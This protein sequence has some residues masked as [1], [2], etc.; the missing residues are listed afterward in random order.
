MKR[1]LLLVFAAITLIGCKSYEQQRAEECIKRHLKCPSSLKV[2][3][4]YDIFRDE[5]ID[6]DTTYHISSISMRTQAVHIDSLKQSI[7]TY[8]AHHYCLITFDAQNLMGAMV[9]YSET[10]VVEKENAELWNDWFNYHYC[11][12]KDS[13]WAEKLTK[14]P[15]YIYS[16][17]RGQ[18][19]NKN[20]FE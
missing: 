9:R 17:Y 7:R 18:W 8:P 16:V 15:K 20:D 10:V 14:K 3:S 5:D 1:I 11:L 4:F 19:C 13:I 12:S 2:I 6:V